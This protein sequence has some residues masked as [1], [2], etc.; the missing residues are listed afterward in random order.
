MAS[1]DQ[2]FERDYF[3]AQDFVEQFGVNEEHVFTIAMFD[4]RESWDNDERRKIPKPVIFLVELPKP[5]FLNRTNHEALRARFGHGYEGNDRVI[6]QKV[7]IYAYQKSAGVQKPMMS[8][9]EILSKMHPDQHAAIGEDLAKRWA[10]RVA[11]FGGSHSAFMKW[12]QPRAH[13]LFELLSSCEN[14]AEF[15]RLTLQRMGEYVDEHEREVIRRDSK[16]PK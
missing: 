11:V 16:N 2:Y 12:L 14:V 13:K 6:G 8:V 9:V 1:F 4:L 3:S 15:P 10:A 5:L 7:T